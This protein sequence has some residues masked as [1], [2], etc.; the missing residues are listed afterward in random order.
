MVEQAQFS[1]NS[2]G[3]IPIAMTERL[4]RVTLSEFWRYR[5]M[6]LVDF[7]ASAPRLC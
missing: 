6:T 2:V 4:P 3:I 7:P 5:R 1:R